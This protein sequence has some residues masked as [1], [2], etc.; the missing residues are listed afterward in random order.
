MKIILQL[1]VQKLQN[2]ELLSKNLEREHAYSEHIS[3]YLMS[4]AYLNMDDPLLRKKKI[5]WKRFVSSK[6]KD[7]YYKKLLRY[8]QKEDEMIVLALNQIERQSEE[9]Q[10]LFGSMYKPFSIA[11]IG[12][13]FL[14]NA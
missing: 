1:I 9:D 6:D 12:Y 13:E 8:K 14:S 3:T 7:K 4:L 10:T 11:I 5:L 2:E